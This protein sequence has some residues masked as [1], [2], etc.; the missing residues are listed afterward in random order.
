MVTCLVLVERG[1]EALAATL[2]ALVAGVAEGVV[3]DAVVVQRQRNEVVAQVADA[4]GATLVQSSAGADPWA[5]AAAVARHDWVLLLGDGDVPIDDWIGAVETF[6]AG[7][8]SAGDAAVL[9]RSGPR[10]RAGAAH[11]FGI[12]KPRAGLLLRRGLLTPAGL[13]VRLRPLRLRARIAR[14][15]A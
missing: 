15:S 11:L 10:L 12:R 7:A 8:A 1:P 14:T 13:A 3:G 2:R 5:A 6:L 4:V 9:T